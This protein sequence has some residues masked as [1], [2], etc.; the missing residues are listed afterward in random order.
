MARPERLRIRVGAGVAIRAV[1]SVARGPPA[2]DQRLGVEAQP[3]AEAFQ[4]ALLAQQDVD[5][6]LH[7]RGAPGG[8]REGGGRLP[9]LLGRRGT[10]GRQLAQSLLELGA[11]RLVAGGLVARLLDEEL[12]L[13]ELGLQPGDLL[14]GRPGKVPGADR[15]GHQSSGTRIQPCFMA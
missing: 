11:L 2:A 13:V 4:D 5:L 3:I 7:Q 8:R 10:A 1:G 6:R 9:D 15:V 12:D 14:S